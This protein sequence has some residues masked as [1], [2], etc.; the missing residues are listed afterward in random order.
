MSSFI[1]H[2]YV[3]DMHEFIIITTRLKRGQNNDSYNHD[4]LVI[5]SNEKNNFVDATCINKSLANSYL[6]P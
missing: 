3:K 6:Q 2:I 5:I 4:P 1:K